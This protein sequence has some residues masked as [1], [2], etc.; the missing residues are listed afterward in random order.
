MYL[1]IAKE[2]D[3]CGGEIRVR[4]MSSHPADAEVDAVGGPGKCVR[5]EVALVEIAGPVVSIPM[6]GR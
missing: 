5:T 3:D 6:G 4:L 2:C 1:I